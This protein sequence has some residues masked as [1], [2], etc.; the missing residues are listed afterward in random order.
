MTQP[1]LLSATVHSVGSIL[2]QFESDVVRARNLGSLLAQEINFDKTT[3]IRIGTA[4]SELSRNILEHAQTGTIEFFLAEREAQTSGIAVIFKDKGKGIEDLNSIQDGNFHSKNGMGV[5]LIGSQ[6]LMDDFEIETEKDKGTTITI[7]K[8]LPRYAPHLDRKRLTVIKN[9]FQKTLERGDSSMVDTI[10]SQ[11]NE[12]VFLLQKLQERNEEIETINQELEET[13]KGVVALNRE[14]EDKAIDIEKAKQEAVMANKAKSEFLANMSHEIRTPM[15]AILGFA[16]ILENKITDKTLK[17]FATAISSSGSSLLGIIN[18]ILDLSKIE[19]GKTELN[20]QSANLKSLINDVGQIFKHKSKE[21]QIDFIIDIDPSIP[22]AIVIDDI[23]LKQILINLIGNAMKFTDKGFVKL[24]VTNHRLTEES[25]LQSVSFCVQDTGI[26]IPQD[27]IENIFG[28]FEQQKN[29][30]LNKF[31]GTGLGL[32]ITKRLVAMMG[33]NLSVESEPDRGSKFCVK[34]DNLEIGDLSDAEA[35]E[36]KDLN[37]QIVFEPATILI[38]DDVAINRK[39][40]IKFIE[41]Y[42]FRIEMAE[43]GQRALDKVDSTLPDLILMDLKMPVMDGFEA[44]SI[45]KANE[46][47]KNIPIVACTASALKEEK[48]LILNS[49]FDAYLRKPFSRKELISELSIHLKHQKLQANTNEQDTNNSIEP[50]MTAELMASLPHFIEEVKTDL[51]PRWE[52]IRDTF[53]LSEISD[54]AIR[55]QKV[56]TKYSAS[57]LTNWSEGIQEQV[58]N[59][60]MEKLPGTINQFEKIVNRYEDRLLKV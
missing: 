46:K 38:V 25:K 36:Q 6:R 43:N 59:L 47:Y 51:H 3:C 60:D 33:G 53:I 27:Q 29:Q 26:G 54:F 55:V 20:Y 7:A 41:D 23:R 22:K 48:E 9:A 17:G 28:A 11:N 4:V 13:N 12:L 32:T 31:G 57:D 19:A 56:A 1:F 58:A 14:L 40:V 16:E 39:L 45:L 44:T 52:T 18:D 37:T 42:D 34:F 2:I 49:G 15:N 10:N 30:D 50:E 35:F 21:K 8:W 5:G 24:S